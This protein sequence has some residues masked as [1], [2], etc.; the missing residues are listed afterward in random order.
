MKFAHTVCGAVLL[1]AI[2]VT[3]TN[4]AHAQLRIGQPSGFTGSAAAGAA[5]SI[6]AVAPLST[7]I[8]IRMEPTI[9]VL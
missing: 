2:A 6:N 7:A 9:A 5:T 3:T 1:A 4:T 8:P